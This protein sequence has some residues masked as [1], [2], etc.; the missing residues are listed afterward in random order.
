M[1]E[2]LPAAEAPE[3]A[4][5]APAAPEPSAAQP[6]KLKPSRLFYSGT[7]LEAYTIVGVSTVLSLISLGFYAPWAVGTAREYLYGRLSMNRKY[8]FAYKGNPVEMAVALGVAAVA[9]LILLGLFHVT[10]THGLSFLTFLVILAG[11]TLFYAAVYAAFY[12]RVRHISLNGRNFVPKAD[13]LEY[14]KLA[15]KRG[16]INLFTIG[17]KL[18]ESDRLKWNFMISRVTYSGGTFS[19]E[20]SAS[21]ARKTGMANMV[22]LWLPLLTGMV[23]V[24]MLSTIPPEAAAKG[25]GNLLTF[26]TLLVTGLGFL[27]RAT[28]RAAMWNLRLSTLRLGPIRFKPT[29]SEKDLVKL[30]ITNALLFFFTAGL[31]YPFI[32]HRKMEFLAETVLISGGADAL[33]EA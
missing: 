16:A 29:A 33:M 28:Y 22:S 32:I 31:A 27:G 1:S 4:A 18:P 14:T 26:L 30:Q 10:Q 8:A 7:P 19:S 6:V 24:M 2:T 15:L 20:M 3:A 23:L 9:I 5:S 21:Q 11:Y 17:F 25:A 13:V 12:I